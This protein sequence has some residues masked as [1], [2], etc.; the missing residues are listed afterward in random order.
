MRQ[1]RKFKGQLNTN[2]AR[3]VLVAIVVS[4]FTLSARVSLSVPL[5]LAGQK[6]LEGEYSLTGRGYH[7][8]SLERLPIQPCYAVQVVTTGQHRQ[9]HQSLRQMTPM[10]PTMPAST[11]MPRT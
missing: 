10:Q 11:V 1:Y 6:R 7:S 3:P 8:H 4:Y 9:C 5:R 2:M